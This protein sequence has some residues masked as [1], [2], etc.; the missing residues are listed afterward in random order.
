MY[1][2]AIDLGGTI[3]KIGLLDGQQLLRLKTIEA[4]TNSE[5]KPNITAIENKVS[6][7]INELDI[8]TSEILGIGFSFPG[9]VDS[10]LN[11]ILSTNKYEDAVTM[12]LNQWTKIDGI[13]LF[14]WKMM[15]GWP[16]S[17]N[18]NMVQEGDLIIL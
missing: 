6:E 7:L 4:V 2:I 15:Q 18:G 13:Y 5:L 1:T 14:F 12:N 16:Y 3:I 11:R 10:D 9:L 17:V 8:I